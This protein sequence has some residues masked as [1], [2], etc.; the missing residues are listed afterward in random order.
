VEFDLQEFSFTSEFNFRLSWFNISC[1]HNGTNVFIDDASPASLRVSFT[2]DLTTCFFMRIGY[3]PITSNVRNN[4]NGESDSV[5]PEGL[6]TYSEVLLH[7]S[8]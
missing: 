2:G 7:Y 8:T 1:L 4:A 6:V 5:W 3:R